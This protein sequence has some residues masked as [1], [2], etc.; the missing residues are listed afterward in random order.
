MVSPTITEQETYPVSFVRSFVCSDFLISAVFSRIV[1][2]VRL[3]LI[4]AK[5]V[6]VCQATWDYR[7]LSARVL[8]YKDNYTCQDFQQGTCEDAK[9]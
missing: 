7:K 5:L 2:E 9:L 6:L 3:A 1:D 8:W 4:F